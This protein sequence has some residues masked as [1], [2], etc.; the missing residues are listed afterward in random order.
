R[1][2]T[3]RE[4]AL[5]AGVNEAIIFRHFATKSELYSAIIDQK[6]CSTDA[7][8]MQSAL[9]EAVDNK[10]DRQVFELLAFHLLE[11]HDRDE[12]AMRLLLYS[13]LEGHELADMIV[14]SHMSKKQQ[15]MADYVKR[16]IADGA[17]RRVDPL[18]AVRGFMGMV[19]GHV[20]NKK[21]FE[22]AGGQVLNITNRQA[23]ERF[24]DLFLASMTNF[25]YE[26]PR[27]RRK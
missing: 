12:T 27:Q 20:M 13:A 25:N 7:Q 14:R 6:A 3:T 19:V 18:T 11:F 4:I 23:A 24:T 17:F 9:D 21:F 15:Q 26:A 10:D 8:A 2:T 1:G 16:R 22:R 5:A